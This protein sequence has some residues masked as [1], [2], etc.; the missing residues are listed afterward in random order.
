MV[1]YVKEI[2]MDYLCI[3]YHYIKENRIEEISMHNATLAPSVGRILCH[4][5]HLQCGVMYNIPK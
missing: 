5:T 3:E 4:V 2:H 1:Q